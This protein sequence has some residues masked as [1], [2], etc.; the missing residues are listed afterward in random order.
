MNHK[1]IAMINQKGGVGKTT[2]I[3]QPPSFI[4]FVPGFSSGYKVAGVRLSVM[5]YGLKVRDYGFLT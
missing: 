4:S 2:S 1:V 3:F 5:G